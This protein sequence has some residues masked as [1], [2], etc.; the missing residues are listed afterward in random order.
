MAITEVSDK[1]RYVVDSAP[2]K[3]NHYTPGTHIPIVS[4][5]VLFSD[6]IGTVLVIA[7]SYTNEVCQII[8]SQSERAIN[9]AVLEGGSIKLVD[10]TI[11]ESIS[12][13]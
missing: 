3:Q 5:E 4:P 10:E 2:F 8:R 11:S 1:V 13:E 7:G 6:S 12:E 9:I